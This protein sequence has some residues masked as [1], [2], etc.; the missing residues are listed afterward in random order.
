MSIPLPPAGPPALP[1]RRPTDNPVS[2]FLR[3]RLGRRHPDAEAF[4]RAW[5]R[6]ETLVIDVYRAGA[7]DAADEAE[8]DA[9]AAWLRE[10]YPDVAEVLAGHWAGVKAGGV[11]LDA[12]PFMAVLDAARAAD[13]VGSRRTMQLLP[14]AREALNGWLAVLGGD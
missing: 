8:F 11:P 9:V 1:P 13:Y 3:S 4:T 14:A 12:D 5:D 2:R 10:H 7:A 6:L